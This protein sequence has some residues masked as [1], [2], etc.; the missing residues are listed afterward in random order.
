MEW[1]KRL[2]L[3]R[4]PLTILCLIALSGCSG[5]P[6]DLYAVN[7]NGHDPRARPLDIRISPPPDSSKIVSEFEHLRR[8]IIDRY[9]EYKPTLQEVLRGGNPPYTHIV[10]TDEAC[11]F[12]NRYTFD[13]LIIA[14]Q[15]LLKTEYWS[16]DVVAIISTASWGPWEGGRALRDQH[17]RSP[18]DQ[19]TWPLKSEDFVRHWWKGRSSEW[20]IVRGELSRN[21]PEEIERTRKDMETLRRQGKWPKDQ[22]K[23]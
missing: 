8:P 22:K 1:Q 4:T 10:L 7:P 3:A 21:S 23:G 14:L 18:E 5:I 11:D 17:Y 2:E 13:E 19:G 9:I 12:I 16:G 20:S 6:K 15:P